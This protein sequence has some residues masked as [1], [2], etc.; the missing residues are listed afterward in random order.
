[1]V[2][3]RLVRHRPLAD[4]AITN[5]TDAQTYRPLACMSWL[6]IAVLLVL[7]MKE[8]IE[9][10][11]GYDQKLSYGVWGLITVPYLS[12]PKPASSPI[13]R[14]ITANA[15]SGTDLS[16]LGPMH[17][18][19]SA[20]SQ[21]LAQ[22]RHRPSLPTQSSPR[23]DTLSYYN[24]SYIRVCITMPTNFGFRSWR[25]YEA[26]I[27]S[28]ALGIYLYATFV[29]TSIMFLSADKAIGFATAM[30]TCLSAVRV[31]TTLF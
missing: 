19:A 8:S 14:P 3:F 25:W 11:D 30:T 31:L 13:P 18:S 7:W 16:N 20:S 10:Y 27:E 23:T 12:P 28:L 2:S 9:V 24:N 22:L 5:E 21:S 17:T 1:M 26:I 15:E 29:M 6:V 4:N